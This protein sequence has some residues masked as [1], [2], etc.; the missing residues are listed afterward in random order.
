MVSNLFYVF[1]A[2]LSLDTWA[3][4][5]QRPRRVGAAVAREVACVRTKLNDECFGVGCDLHNDPLDVSCAE[6]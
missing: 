4:F 6:K 2:A 1:A 5:K 3:G